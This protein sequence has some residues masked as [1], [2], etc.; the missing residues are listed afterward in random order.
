MIQTIIRS[1]NGKTFDEIAE[2]A[3]EEER[4]IFSMKERYRQGT[5]FGSVVYRNGGK[6]GRL[7]AICYLKDK[8]DVRVNKLRSESWRKYNQNSRIPKR[9]HW[10]LQLCSRGPYVQRM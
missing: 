4:A 9:R 8:K 3:L 10:V 2:T 5:T 1:R 6:T 7:A